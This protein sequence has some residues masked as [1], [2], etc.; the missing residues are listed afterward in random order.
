MNFQ[1]YLESFF[2]LREGKIKSSDIQKT[3]TSII[4]LP[5]SFTPASWDKW[6]TS[7]GGKAAIPAPFLKILEGGST[8][9]RAAD[10]RK[11][12][13]NYADNIRVG[14][15]EQAIAIKNLKEEIIKT[16][17]TT[18]NA[19]SS[20]LQRYT[21]ARK[22]NLLSIPEENTFLG[23]SIMPA[24]KAATQLTQMIKRGD[25]LSTIRSFMDKVGE[26]KGYMVN[27]IKELKKDKEDEIA[28][29][30]G[31]IDPTIGGGSDYEINKLLL[32][33]ETKERMTNFIA[34]YCRSGSIE[35]LVD[36][37]NHEPSFKSKTGIEVSALPGIL[38]MKDISQSIKNSI[39]DSLFTKGVFKVNMQ[40][41]KIRKFINEKRKE[42]F[43]TARE[44]GRQPSLMVFNH[45]ISKELGFE[46][47][48]QYEQMLSRL[49][50]KNAVGSEYYAHLVSMIASHVIKEL[51]LIS[52]HI[53]IQ[54]QE[55]E[56]KS[57]TKIKM[58]IPML[59]SMEVAEFKTLPGFNKVNEKKSES[60]KR[61]I[62]KQSDALDK[63]LRELTNAMPPELKTVERLQ[64]YSI[65]AQTKA[66]LKRLADAGKGEKLDDASF[67]NEI[68][69][70]YGQIVLGKLFAR[71]LD[72]LDNKQKNFYEQSVCIRAI[73]ELSKASGTWRIKHNFLYSQI[74]DMADSLY[75]AAKDSGDNLDR[76]L[77]KP[78]LEEKGEDTR[79]GRKPDTTRNN[80]KDPDYS[81]QDWRDRK[82]IDKELRGIDKRAKVFADFAPPYLNWKGDPASPAIQ[83]LFDI[84]IRDMKNNSVFQEQVANTPNGIQVL[85]SNWLMS[86]HGTNTISE[87]RDSQLR[88][89]DKDPE[90][91]REIKFIEAQIYAR[92]YARIQQSLEASTGYMDD[93]TGWF[94]P[95][96][97]GSYLDKKAD[98]VVIK[99][100]GFDAAKR[101][102]F[103]DAASAGDYLFDITKKIPD[104]L[105]SKFKGYSLLGMIHA[106]ETGDELG[107]VMSHIHTLIPKDHLDT[108]QENASVKVSDVHLEKAGQIEQ[109]AKEQREELQKHSLNR[110][111]ELQGMHNTPGV[112]P[113]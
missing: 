88:T 20:R 30:V 89:V 79:V 104:E 15:A 86:K 11:L 83:K 96:K 105:Q 91:A 61:Q 13:T 94:V 25:S 8:G 33:F 29:L 56:T 84:Y 87:M 82:D 80:S 95:Q 66:T 18:F 49:I 31:Q 48:G 97:R 9:G 28:S 68:F 72:E 65:P 36:L 53:E 5:S 27:V 112:T 43:K 69:N 3:L 63:R 32:A 14:T 1:S 52:N 26:A 62:A 81:F 2:T 41:P 90:V 55:I 21:L 19:E 110:Q 47:Q 70:E 76:I 54:E 42:F 71:A 102:E 93:K 6:L 37:L 17:E 77:E 23:S 64:H 60:Q 34:K 22:N 40:S 59:E 35:P 51:P 39:S 12:I 7:Y 106:A 99:T 92:R 85:F 78:R 108:L 57:G 109:K 4:N 101:D 45:V 10:I 111:Q 58:K 38:N 24:S 103:L 16:F 67:V 98:S 107:M 100:G 74:S 44:T 73:L 113:A 50:D 46:L 75:K